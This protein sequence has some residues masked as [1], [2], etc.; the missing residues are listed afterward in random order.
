MYV[1]MCVCACVRERERDPGSNIL[2]GEQLIN[3]ITE[4]N[5]IRLMW[6]KLRVESEK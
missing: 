6:V 4:R 1:C 5:K 3:R 2:S